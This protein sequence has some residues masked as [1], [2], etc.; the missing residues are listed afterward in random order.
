MEL[1]F[2]GK[3]WRESLAA[4]RE[5]YNASLSGG[6]AESIRLIHGYGSTGVGGGLKA[7]F[8]KYLEKH[9]SRLSFRPGEEI[10]AN[11]GW[12][13]VE[14]AR[15]LP[16]DEEVLEDLILDYCRQPRTLDK[17]A[18]KFRRYGDPKVRQAIKSLSAPPALLAR[19][20]KSG[21]ELYQS[22]ESVT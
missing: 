19:V 3:T 20:N 22:A 16:E 18:G 4:F 12:T 7:R 15:T 6:G 13:L 1:D 17:I 11:P 14:A 8:R 9:Q 2:H 10:D 21:R 5:A